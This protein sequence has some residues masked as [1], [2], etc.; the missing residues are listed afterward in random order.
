[1]TRQYLLYVTGQSGGLGRCPAVQMPDV[2]HV[3]IK[4]TNRQPVARMRRVTVAEFQRRRIGGDPVPD[5]IIREHRTVREVR[6]D[7]LARAGQPRVEKVLLRPRISAENITERGRSAAAVVATGLLAVLEQLHVFIVSPDEPFID[8]FRFDPRAQGR[9]PDE[10]EAILH[11]I[12]SGGIS[13]DIF[14]VDARSGLEDIVD[15]SDES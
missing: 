7:I 4:L 1:M 5:D 8:P 13:G 11:A 3:R 9:T 14:S 15:H 10:P 6:S 12:E 2:G